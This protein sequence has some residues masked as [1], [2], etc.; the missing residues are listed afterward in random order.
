[1]HYVTGVL[2][3]IREVS[4]YRGAVR[5]R[6]TEDPPLL[7]AV[8]MPRRPR[9]DAEK[10]KASKTMR[11]TLKEKNEDEQVDTATAVTPKYISC[12]DI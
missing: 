11:V 5:A 12:L 4:R 1:M 2:C 8:K 10:T 7:R 9:L 6:N 3:I